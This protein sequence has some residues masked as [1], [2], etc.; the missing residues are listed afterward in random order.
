MDKRG[1]FLAEETLKIVVAV[2]CISFLIFILGKMYYSYSVDKEEQQ[3]KDTLAHIES[4]INSMKEGDIRE[5]MVYSPGYSI[6]REQIDYWIFMG[7]DNANRP[8]YCLEKKWEGCLCLCKNIW[9]EAFNGYEEKCGV[10]ILSDSKGLS[11]IKVDFK[12][13]PLALSVKK[14]DSQLIVKRG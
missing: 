1:F 6:V 12:E 4:E 8:K 2:I 14:M 9:V 13:L 3:A 5:I 7:F 10:C 11:K